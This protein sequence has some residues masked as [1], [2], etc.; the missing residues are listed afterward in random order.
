MGKITR[1]IFGFFQF[2]IVLLLCI[3]LF[4]GSF[5]AI[6]LMAAIVI[7]L[8]SKFQRKRKIA[9][10]LLVISVLFLIFPGS[11][12]VERSGQGFGIKL[13]PIIYGYPSPA[14]REEARENKVILGGCVVYPLAPL[15]AIALRF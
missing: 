13:V 1:S 5:L 14:L 3:S 2:V 10:I 6:L 8:R 4:F 7:N 12:L 15:W 9:I 11:I